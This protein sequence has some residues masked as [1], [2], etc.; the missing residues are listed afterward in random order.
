VALLELALLG[1]LPGVVDVAVRRISAQAA[2]DPDTGRLVDTLEP[3][4]ATLRYGDVRG[5]DA[6]SLRA[7]FDGIV[8]RVLAGLAGACTALNDEAAAAWAPRLTSAQAALSLLDHDARRSG[9][10][11]ALADLS[12]RGDVHGMVQGRATR[13]LHDGEWWSADAV[14]RR[15]S[16][17]LTAGTPAASGAAFVEGFLAG[18]GVVLVHDRELLEVIDGWVAGL[19]PEAFLATA[20]LLRRTFAAFEAGERRQLGLL[21]SDR[22]V[23]TVSG[24]GDELDERRVLAAMRTVRHMLGVPS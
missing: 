5:T 16:R 22:A 12:T 19:D 7:A 15:L 8:V 10:P 4:A 1:A 20:P 11:A 13:L 18:S 6:G 2:H 21:L 3:L 17:A 23:A 9:W 24:Y 14:Q